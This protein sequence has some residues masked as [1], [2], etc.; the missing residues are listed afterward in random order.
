[1]A[2]V[3]LILAILSETAG[4]TSMKY[5]EGFTRLVPSVAVGVFYAVSIVLLTMTLRSID[6]SVAY[7]VWSGVGTAL[8]A[9]IGIAWFGE[10]LTAIKL[11]SLA[12]IVA[13]VVGLN[14]GGAH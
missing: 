9:A 2:W 14:L 5:A 8:I 10:P 4:T 13:G 6:I 7:A 1:M 12:L 3:Y 11:A